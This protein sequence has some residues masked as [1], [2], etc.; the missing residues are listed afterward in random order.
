MSAHW[1]DLYVEGKVYEVTIQ[2]RL[3][4]SILTD[5]DK[6]YEALRNIAGQIPSIEKQEDRFY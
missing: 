6:Y 3:S 5:E 4:V 2:K 1:G